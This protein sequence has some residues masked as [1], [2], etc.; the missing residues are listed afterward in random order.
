MAPL[1]VDDS[2]IVDGSGDAF[3]ISEKFDHPSGTRYV[4]DLHNPAGKPLSIKKAVCCVFPRSWSPHPHVLMH[5]RTRCLHA[6]YLPGFF[7]YD[8]LVAFVLFLEL[9]IRV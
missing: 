8:K 7:L 9:C 3:D 2:P 5:A 6:K 4:S 1:I